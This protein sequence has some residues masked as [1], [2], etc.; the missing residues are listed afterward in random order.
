MH[1]ICLTNK[2]AVEV[3]MSVAD[4]LTDITIK[5]PAKDCRLINM[6]E[7]KP[8]ENSKR[9][10]LVVLQDTFNIHSNDTS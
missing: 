7:K 4:K 5:W 1:L 3:S 10:E 8:E 6:I 9:K 2:G